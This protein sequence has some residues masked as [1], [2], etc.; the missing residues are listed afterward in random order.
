M[1]WLQSRPSTDDASG[2]A[3][4]RGGWKRP[5]PVPSLDELVPLHAPQSGIISPSQAAAVEHVKQLLADRGFGD[6]ARALGDLLAE[7]LKLGDDRAPQTT[8]SRFD[9]RSDGC[10]EPLDFEGTCLPLGPLVAKDASS[11][12]R[13]T[14][15][16]RAFRLAVAEAYLHGSSTRRVGTLA[17]K[18]CKPDL[19]SDQI[20]RAG[21]ALDVEIHEWQGSPLGEFPYVMLHARRE[22]ISQSGLIVACD[23]LMAAGIDKAGKRTVLGVH[24]S[25]KEEAEA[26]W[27]EFIG[28]LQARG[29]H[30]VRMITSDNFPGLKEALKS[31]MPGV[32]MQRGQLRL[33][34]E[35][36]GYVQSQ[37]IRVQLT[38]E[39]SNVFEAPNL[40]EAEAHLALAANTYRST[41]TELAEF[42]ETAVPEGLA[43]FSLPP[44]HRRRL[45]TGNLMDGLDSEIWKRTRLVGLFGDQP[46]VRRIASAVLMEIGEEWHLKGKYLMMERA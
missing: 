22:S 31:R 2:S 10:A 29:L 8:P 32:L 37:A 15:S 41:N 44:R 36:L 45:R 4:T 16:E 3:R 19:T 39:L 12:E 21:A 46:S 6:V 7:V 14:R 35:A 34:K 5:K 9:S 23:V 33:A 11:L 13:G 27:S 1:S 38:I 25:T 40:A 42:L 18:L 17:R 30:G 24:V 26:R 28:S 43:V 20:C